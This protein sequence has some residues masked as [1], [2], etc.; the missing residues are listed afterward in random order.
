MADIID[1]KPNVPIVTRQTFIEAVLALGRTD[2]LVMN[3]PTLLDAARASAWREVNRI[4]EACCNLA[5]DP[6]EQEHFPIVSTVDP[7]VRQDLVDAAALVVACDRL[8]A[9][10]APK[11]RTAP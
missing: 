4:A 7:A 6:A 8:L 1:F 2:G 5:W 11:P 10:V 3:L 9:D